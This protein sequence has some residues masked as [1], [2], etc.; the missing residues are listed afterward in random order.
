MGVENI[1]VEPML[2]TY[3]ETKVQVEKIVISPSVV[4]ASLA[5]K[6]FHLY[7]VSLLGVITKHVFWFDVTGA[8]VAPALTDAV[9]HEVD[10]S[11]G[12]IDTVA[13]IAAELDTVISAVAGIYTATS[14]NNEVTVT[15][16][17]AGYAPAAHDAKNVL[18]VTNFGL[19]LL[20][21]GEV[22]VDLGCLEGNIGVAFTE[23]FVDVKCHSN[24][25]TPVAQLKTGVESVEVTLSMLETTKDKI[26]AMLVKANG[27]FI[28]DGGTELMGMGTFK[29]FENMFKYAS[30]LR[31]H[32]KRLL[33]GDLSE[34]WTFTKA[35]PNLTQIDFSGEEVLKLPVT[36]KVYPAQ[37]VDSR[38]NYWFIG[39]GSQNLA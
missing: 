10:I 39:D 4:K 25:A 24:G 7:A 14:L 30:K 33:A 35:M 2:V 16:V 31:L 20:T 29:T 5:A 26:K 36:F 28:P 8:D 15:H 12:A 18:K 17:V 9:L 3:G 38:I 11:A 21:Q 13:E 27:S 37:D 23:S 19:Q 32:P 1:K 22:P 6:Y 34:D